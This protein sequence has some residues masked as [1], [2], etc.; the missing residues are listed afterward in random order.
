M[1]PSGSSLSPPGVLFPGNCLAEPPGEVGTAL[2][3][4]GLSL[5]GW[6]CLT[7][8]NKQL[9]VFLGMA[10]FKFTA[11]LSY[12]LVPTVLTQIWALL[13]MVFAKAE[14]LGETSPGRPG[15]GAQQQHTFTFLFNWFLGVEVFV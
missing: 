14:I 2:G 1:R 10:F 3:A 8:K 9:L 7:L 5:L 13:G 11:C 6:P 4:V 12:L 15:H